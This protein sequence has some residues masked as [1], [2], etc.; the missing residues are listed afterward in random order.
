[1]INIMKVIMKDSS[2][3][4]I[5]DISEFNKL[6]INS[7]YLGGLFVYDDSIKGL[8]WG[9]LFEIITNININIL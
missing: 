5:D 2:N 9:K 3:Q 1:M 8:N 4:F 6:L 7:Q